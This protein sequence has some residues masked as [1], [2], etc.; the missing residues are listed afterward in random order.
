MGVCA[1][2]CV[3]ACTGVCE[4]LHVCVQVC[5]RVYVCAC[6]CARTR[7]CGGAWVNGVHLHHSSRACGHVWVAWPLLSA[8]CWRRFRRWNWAGCH[9]PSQ[10][11]PASRGARCRCGRA[12]APRT[13]VQV[14]S[15]PI[16]GWHRRPS[17]ERSPCSRSVA[18]RL[19]AQQCERRP[20]GQ[21]LCKASLLGPETASGSRVCR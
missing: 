21:R 12:Q 14:S 13:G 11:P 8:A 6:V 19:R 2:G 16:R 18:P 1:C 3:C 5:V 15:P 9:H 4:D 17:P 7:V 10:L 20:G